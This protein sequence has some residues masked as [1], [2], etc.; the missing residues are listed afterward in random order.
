MLHFCDLKNKPINPF[1][2]GHIKTKRKSMKITQKTLA[3]KVEVQISTIQRIENGLADPS[4]A[5]LYD[6]IRILKL[7]YQSLFIES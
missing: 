1:L 5:T 3:E 7:D 4:T 6:I 2:G